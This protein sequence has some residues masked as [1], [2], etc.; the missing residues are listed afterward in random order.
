MTNII[1]RFLQEAPQIGFF[2]K[3]IAI[4]P[5][6]I[7]QIVPGLTTNLKKATQSYIEGLLEMDDSY[8]KNTSSPYLFSRLKNQI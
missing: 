6:K 2:K 7:Q 8:L 1:R 5:K 3:G 4:H